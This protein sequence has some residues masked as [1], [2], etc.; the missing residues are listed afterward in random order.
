MS[1]SDRESLR[2]A[3]AAE[4]SV[5]PVKWSARNLSVMLRRTG[6]PPGRLA[7][8]RDLL[9]ALGLDQRGARYSWITT[10]GVFDHGEFWGRAG[11]PQMI[12][13]HPYDVGDRERGW[14]ADLARFTTL[15]VRLDDRPSYYGFGTHHVRVA[16][17]EVRSPFP[18]VPSTPGTR[19]YARRARRA[20]AEELL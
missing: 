3:F 10:G 9:G 5:R 12:V 2:S 13:G 15:S 17:A 11:I 14:L 4:F 18:S 7:E 8:L 6:E 20:F 1:P 16:L 19:A